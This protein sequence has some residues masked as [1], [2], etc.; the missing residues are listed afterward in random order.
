M[1][2]PS[3]NP[4]P[5]TSAQPAGSPASEEQLLAAYANGDQAAFPELFRR[6]A[7]ALGRAVRTHVGTEDEVRD[8]VPQTFLQLPRAR[9]DYRPGEPVRPWLFTI[10]YNLCRD[11]KRARARRR[12]VSLDEAPPA[13]T[14]ETPA[15]ELEAKRRAARLRVALAR[16]PDDQRRVLEMHWFGEVPLAEV[17]IGLGVSLSAVKVRAHR[18][19][20][21]L[22]EILES[23]GGL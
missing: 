4:Y 6:L 16:L 2:D 18:A 22:R 7:P 8:L 15:D 20:Q 13:C 1:S 5:P 3:H 14:C 12:E 10:A 17:A 19:Y 21:R 9:R 11:Q 23:M